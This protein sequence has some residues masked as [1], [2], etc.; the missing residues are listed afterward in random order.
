VRPAHA[1]FPGPHAGGPM[2]PPPGTLT[3]GDGALGALVLAAT[4]ADAPAL[5]AGPGGP[6]VGAGGGLG[7]RVVVAGAGVTGGRLAPVTG[8]QPPGPPPPPGGGCQG[9]GLVVASGTYASPGSGAVGLGRSGTG[10]EG[11]VHGSGVAVGRGTTTV[12]TTVVVTTD[13]VGALGERVRRLVGEGVARVEGRPQGVVVRQGGLRQGSLLPFGLP[14]RG[15]PVGAT[16]MVVGGGLAPPL[17]QGTWFDCW[18][19]GG[20]RMVMVVVDMMYV[21]EVTGLGQ[22]KPDTV[23]VRVERYGTTLM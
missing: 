17:L 23:L 5:A 9:A 10:S 4:G 16:M 19:P 7:L 1:G 13:G 15:G 11:R 18:P 2:S 3:P 21:Y 8:V 6:G 12:L 14:L 20:S 22:P